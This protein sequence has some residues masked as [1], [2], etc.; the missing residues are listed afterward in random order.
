MGMAFIK[1]AVGPKDYEDI[2]TSFESSLAKNIR[3]DD[4]KQQLDNLPSTMMIRKPLETITV[5]TKFMSVRSDSNMSP[6]SSFHLLKDDDVEVLNDEGELLK[7]GGDLKFS[8]DISRPEL[9]AT[10]NGESGLVILNR[11]ICQGIAN[12]IKAD[13]LGYNVTVTNIILN[14]VDGGATEFTVE[15]QLSAQ[16]S[17]TILDAERMAKKIN[18]ALAQAMDD[19]EVALAMGAAAKVENSW[20]I[21][22]RDRIIEE[23]LFEVDDADDVKSAVLDDEDDFESFRD[24]VDERETSS[25]DRQMEKDLFDG[26]F[27]MPGD[28]IYGKNDIFLG[29]GN[30]GVFFDYSEKGLERAPFKGSLGPL[31]LDSVVQR[32]LQR[33]P[34]LIAIG[35]VHG[36]IDEL[37][38][39]LRKCDYRIGDLVLFLGDLV[40]KGPDSLSVVQMA[41][42]I[43]AIGVRGNHDFE[44]IRWHQAI[45]SGKYFPR[46]ASCRKLPFIWSQLFHR[47]GPTSD[48][49]RA[50][51]N[52][53]AIEQ[54]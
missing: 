46:F 3:N 20:P 1:W 28:T 41:R 44:V 32:S 12:A 45:K 39:L 29:G 19:G 27:G 8:M 21:T 54:G 23:F 48:R 5:E 4:E 38:A 47:G 15:F 10:F 14:E 49:I 37:Q 42:E 53:Y 52:C 31:L 43:G 22:L 11:V 50:F 13:T 35:D 18:A 24:K 33:H 25:N 34:R 7:L 51:S 2:I 26:P 6:P 36:C 40:S 30:G 16:N 17:L 9:E